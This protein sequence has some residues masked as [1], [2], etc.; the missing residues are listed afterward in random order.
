MQVTWLGYPGTSGLEAMDY[1]LTDPYLDPQDENRPHPNP[2]PEYQERGSEAYAERSIRLPHTFWCLDREA[3]EGPEIPAVNELPAKR[4]GFV[5]FGCLN[6]FCKLNQ[7]LLELWK[8]VLDGVKDSRMVILAPLGSRRDWVRKTLGDRVDFVQRQPR[9]K[10]LAFY[11]R[12]DIG[13]DT[14]PYNGHTTSLDSLWMGVPVVTMIGKTV[15]GR[16]GF[17]QLSNLGLTELVAKTDREFVEIA[18]ELAGDW[19]RLLQLRSSLRDRTRGS[20]LMDGKKFA[21]EVEKA[22]RG[23]WDEY[24]RSGAG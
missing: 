9:A 7:P 5:T 16:A 21:A 14:L 12:I 15:V 8:Q 17:S 19:E 10:Y 20:A 18:I 2:L 6:N 4:N 11:N 13:L 1:R 23:M 22:Y 24:C 3:L